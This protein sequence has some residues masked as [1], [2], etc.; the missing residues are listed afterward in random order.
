MDVHLYRSL[1]HHC[2]AV[3]NRS[4][5]HQAPQQVFML[6][7]MLPR[8]SEVEMRLVVDLSGVL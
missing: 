1:R 7:R 4:L 5:L 8:D 6:V 2:W 3:P